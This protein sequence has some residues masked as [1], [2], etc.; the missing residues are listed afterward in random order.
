MNQNNTLVEKKNIKYFTT[1]KH[2]EKLELTNFAANIGE[3]EVDDTP[4][5]MQVSCQNNLRN[6]FIQ[7]KLVYAHD[8]TS[9]KH[10]ARKSKLQDFYFFEQCI[11]REKKVQLIYLLCN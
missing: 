11:Y 8:D 5:F 2:T 1:I 6:E 9:T 3:N 7:R 10:P 4:T